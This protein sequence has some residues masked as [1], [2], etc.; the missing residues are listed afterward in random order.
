MDRRINRRKS[1]PKSFPTSALKGSPMHYFSTSDPTYKCVKCYSSSIP[2]NATIFY[3]WKI[4]GVHSKFAS[5]RADASRSNLVCNTLVSED[6]ISWLLHVNSLAVQMTIGSL[7]VLYF[8]FIGEFRTKDF[9]C[10]TRRREMENE[11]L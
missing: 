4:S 9:S 8:D 7:F 3:F 2:T 11:M 6:V 10:C 1:S 5:D